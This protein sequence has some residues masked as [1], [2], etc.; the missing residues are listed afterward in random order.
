MALLGMKL[1][2]RRERCG[3]I[4]SAGAKVLHAGAADNFSRYR[5]VLR[6]LKTKERLELRGNPEK[7]LGADLRGNLDLK[8]HSAHREE[9]EQQEKSQQA[10]NSRPGPETL[11]R[12][13]SNSRQAVFLSKIFPY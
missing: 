9:H 1:A 4:P 13:C 5:S 2:S 11:R 8:R 12:I 6:A 10:T 7:E 3:P